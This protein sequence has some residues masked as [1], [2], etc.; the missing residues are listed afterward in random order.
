MKNIYDDSQIMSPLALEKI[1]KEYA[2]RKNSLN[3]L[4]GFV[5]DKLNEN[6]A[7][8]EQLSFKCGASCQS[9]QKHAIKT[10]AI[11]KNL[12]PKVN[13][14]KKNLPNTIPKTKRLC[15]QNSINIVIYIAD[16]I[17]HCMS[18]SE[19]RAIKSS[20]DTIVSIVDT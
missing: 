11:I 6:L 3:S 1:A 13:V 15:I 19:Y 10:Y 16:K 4:D 14:L 12:Q 8:L 5:I 17:K 20:L 2:Q 18:D 7:L 9:F